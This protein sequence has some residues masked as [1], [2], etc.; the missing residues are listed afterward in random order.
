MSRT[1]SII[2]I[3]LTIAYLGALWFLFD[4]RLVEIMLMKPNEIGDL[5]AG[6]FGPLAI[7]WL[8]LGFFQQGIELRQNT[9]ALELQA[10]EL[11]KSVEHQKEM[12]EVSK[13]QLLAD[14]EAIQEEREK[15]R[16][17]ALPRFVFSSMGLMYGPSSIGIVY[18]SN[19]Q[20]IGN[21]VTDV[22]ISC[23]HDISSINPRDFA[24]FESKSGHKIQWHS[25]GKDPASDSWILIEYVDTLG[26]HGEQ[27][28]Q[29]VV[30]DDG[31][32]NGAIV[33]SD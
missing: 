5:L 32:F 19:L 1:L 16:K 9:K 10:E 4:G 15:E 7:L 26:I 11:R 20:N 30:G 14:L 6:A 27:K 29:P 24:S 18:T 8:I 22:K 31:Q 3:A 17:N 12:V 2:G 25:S 33:P 28:F 13:E 21:T 23:S